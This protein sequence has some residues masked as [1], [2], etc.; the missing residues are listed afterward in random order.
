MSTSLARHDTTVTQIT[1]DQVDLWKRTYCKGASDDEAQLFVNVCKR[2]GL[3]PEARHIYLIPRWDAREKR[4][5]MQTM[6]SIDGF[7]VV[8]ER[9]GEYEGQIPPAWRGTSGEWVDVWLNPEPPSAARIGVYRHGF[10]E[11]LIAVATYGEY[12]VKGRDG[13]PSGKWRDAPA[14]MLAKCAEALALRKAFPQDLSGLY[15]TD[16]MSRTVSESAP[17]ERVDALEPVIVAAETSVYITPD[18]R[19]KLASIASE[20]GLSP[21]AARGVLR[22]TIGVESTADITL[23]D[24]ELIVDAFRNGGHA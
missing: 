15:T 1:R 13:L 24:Y 5:I 14:T 9:T 6:V 7:R 18:Q 21:D 19:R 20:H 22:D 3:S 8:A 10:R 12:V 17:A 11:P 23:D 2:T 16:E 4:Q